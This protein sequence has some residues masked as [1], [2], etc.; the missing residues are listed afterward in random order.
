MS[1]FKL[2]TVKFGH[3]VIFYAAYPLW[4]TGKLRPIPADLWQLSDGLHSTQQTV[5]TWG[6]YAILG[7]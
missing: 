1:R 5:F 3:S 2:L 7:T 6:N 4:F